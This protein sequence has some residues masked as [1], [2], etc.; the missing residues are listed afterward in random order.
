MKNDNHFRLIYCIF[1]FIFDSKHQLKY[2][3]TSEEATPRKTLSVLW[4]ELTSRF[5]YRTPMLYMEGFE[6]KPT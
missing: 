5:G 2:P 6:G 1:S 4:F 3:I